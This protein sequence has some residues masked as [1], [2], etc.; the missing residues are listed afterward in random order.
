[1]S[2]P[3]LCWHPWPHCA[4]IIINIALSLL[5]ALC[6][7]HCPCRVGA[8]ALVALT[9]LP[10]LP[11]RHRQ[12]R[13]LA[14][15]QSQSS[16]NMRWHH[17]QYRAVVIASIAPALSPSLHRHLCPCCTGAATLGTPALPPA[18]QTGICPVMTQL[19]HVVSEAL[20]LPST[21]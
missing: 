12:H 4:G 1:M 5:P 18:S 16:R 7:H 19:H 20:L 10:S 15:A 11:S 6:W 8:F 9:L 2:L 17:C 21:S 13:E 14:S 3:A